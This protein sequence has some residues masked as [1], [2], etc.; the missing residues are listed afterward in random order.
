MTLLGIGDRLPGITLADLEGRPVE[1]AA[2]G[3]RPLLIFVWA[4]W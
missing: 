1:L 4:S 3:S 2:E